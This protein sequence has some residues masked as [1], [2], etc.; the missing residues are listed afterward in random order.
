[1]AA[2]PV[3]VGE[4]RLFLLQM[5]R[6][7]QQDLEQIGGAARAIHRTLEAVPDKPRQVARVID[8]RV[9]QDDGGERARIER[10]PRPV[11]QAQG[12]E[13]LEEPAVEQESVPAVLEKMLGAGDGAACGPEKG[14]GGARGHRHGV[15]RPAPRSG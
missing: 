10:R 14:D 15:Y 7:P 4:A 12:L 5:R 13:S 1:M 3:P 6:V 8:V 9:A 11:P 2:R